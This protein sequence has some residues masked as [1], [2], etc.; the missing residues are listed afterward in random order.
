VTGRLGRWLAGLL[1]AA[2]AGCSGGAGGTGAGEP[3]A[4]L[5][6]RLTSAQARGLIASADGAWLAWLEG[7]VE[8]RGRYL[9]PGTSSC[10]LKVVSTAAGAAGPVTVARAVTSLPHGASFAPEGHLLAALEE[11]DYEAG[12]GTLVL[13][14]DGAARPVARG[15]TFHGFLPAGAGGDSALLAVAGGKLLAVP[16]E[17]APREL[18][19]AEGVASFD[20]APAPWQGRA[21]AVLARR[22]V[23][24]GGG[25]LALGP[26]LEQARPVA[27]ATSEFG[28]APGDGWA[29][30]VLGRG[31]AE[32]HLGKGARSA[33]LAG[34]ARSFAFSADGAALAWVSDAAPGKQGDLHVAKVGGAP[35]VLG[36]EVGEHRWAARAPRLAWLE[37]YDPRTRTGVLGAGG[38]ALAPRTFGR[39]VSDFEVAPDGTQVA[40][41]R[42]TTEGGYSVDLELAAVE[43]AAAGVVAPRKVA[44]GVFGFAFSPDG[45]WLYYRTRCTRQAEACDLERVA[46]AGAAGTAPE[47]LAKGVKSFEFDP[48]DPER[49]LITWQRADLVALDLAIWQAGRLTAVD[50]GAL[51]GSIRFVGPDSGRLCYAVVQPRRAGVYLATLPAR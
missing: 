39:A 20:Y 21:V 33:R 51:A 9:P 31:G 44:R 3:G 18:Q 35:V 6:R 4:G 27:N 8:V 40:Y 16:A 23:S 10:E 7:C 2:L 26:G 48:K 25:L 17:G 37:R 46:V 28:L 12:A 47:E 41:L 29:F 43:G 11:Y 19:G 14:K 1:A 13:V 49:L 5:G 45:R 32:L 50:Q 30:T 24:A 22:P 34:G 36:Q 42:H 38:P 15:V